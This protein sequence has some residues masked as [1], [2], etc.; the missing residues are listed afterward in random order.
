MMSTT[1]VNTAAIKDRATKILTTPQTEWPVI[2][3]EQTD[4]AKLFTGYIMILAAI[5]A[6]A[7]FIGSSIFAFGLF[8]VSLALGLATAI[9]SYALTLCGTY[10]SAFIIDKLAPT[11]DSRASLIQALKLT[12]YASTA[13]WV[14]GVANILPIIGTIVVLVGSL[15]SIYLFYLGLPVMMKTPQAKVI[16]YMVVCALVMIVVFIVIGMITAAIVGTAFVAA[17]L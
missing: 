10:V 5:P 6:I 15:Y 8:R 2:E 3:A 1:E 4:V 16:P 17:S 14:A 9:V 7:S 13:A 11:F 12:A